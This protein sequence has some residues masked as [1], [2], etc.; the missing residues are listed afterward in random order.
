MIAIHR[1]VRST[2]GVLE[3]DIPPFGPVA[4]IVL[5]DS[6]RKRSSSLKEC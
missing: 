2:L 4:D 5:K 1:S 6:P 3:S